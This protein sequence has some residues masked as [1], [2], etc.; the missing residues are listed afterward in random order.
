MSWT[1]HAKIEMKKDRLTIV[2]VT[3]VLRGGVVDEPESENGAWRYQVRTMRMVVQCELCGDEEPDE[4][5]VI[6]VWRIQ[7]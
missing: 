1:E 6:T 2:D 5:R 3:D 7:S 4:L